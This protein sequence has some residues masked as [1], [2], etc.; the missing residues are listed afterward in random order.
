MINGIKQRSVV[1]KDGKIEIP[2]SELPEGATI[3]IIVLVESPEP[4]ETE[5]LLSDPTNR[6]HLL[7]AIESAKNPE[8]LVVISAEEWHEKHRV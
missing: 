7:E 8:N 4:D 6:Q 5:Y 3:E 1:G 2:S